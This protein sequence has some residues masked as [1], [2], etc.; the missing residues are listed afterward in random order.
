MQNLN[1]AGNCRTGIICLKA[2][3]IVSNLLSGCQDLLDCKILFQAEVEVVT[4]VQGFWS[5]TGFLFA[6]CFV[7][8]TD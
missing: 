4:V 3:G 7:E 1:F 5:D 2:L 8:E 6:W